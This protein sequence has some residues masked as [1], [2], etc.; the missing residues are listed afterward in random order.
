MNHPFDMGTCQ[1]CSMVCDCSNYYKSFIGEF[2]LCGL[3][4]CSNMS[5][6]F[7]TSQLFS[8]CLMSAS[9]K[10]TMLAGTFLIWNISNMRKYIEKVIWNTHPPPRIYNPLPPPDI[11]PILKLLCILPHPYFCF[12]SYVSIHKE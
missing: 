2:S 7:H 11:I 6:L 10:D 4:P 8:H 5:F 9:H 3:Q 12:P 1:D